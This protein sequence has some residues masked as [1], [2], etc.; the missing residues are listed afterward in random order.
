MG[1]LCGEDKN[2]QTAETVDAG[3]IVESG[4]VIAGGAKADKEP[5]LVITIVGVRGIRMSDDVPDPGHSKRDCYCEVKGGGQMLWT[6]SAIN[7]CCEPV[8]AEEYPVA[9]LDDSSPL[10]FA[11]YSK[12][13]DSGDL[14][15]DDSDLLGMALLDAKDFEEGFNGELR[16]A[17]S[18]MPEARIRVKVKVAGKDLPRGPDPEFAVTLERENKDKSWGGKFNLRDEVTLQVLEMK[19]GPFTEYNKGAP[20][21]QQIRVNDFI[22]KVND[23]TGSSKGMLEEFKKSLKVDLTIAPGM[24]SAIIYG[25]GE[26]DSPLGLAFANE[27]KDSEVLVV[28]TVDPA[29]HNEKARAHEKILKGDRIVSVSGVEGKE[30]D[31]LKKLK[32]STGKV[33]LIVMRPRTSKNESEACLLR[34]RHSAP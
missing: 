15:R 3:G 5:K 4:P 1:N 11:V 7:D 16:L 25:R 34:R 29:K 24:Y 18:K 23:T 6:T 33:E 10:E 2:S 19:E 17:D 20:A 27:Q 26:A 9:E 14:F 8:W 30:G 13:K 22:V 32:E 31:L 28:K 12:D 21:D